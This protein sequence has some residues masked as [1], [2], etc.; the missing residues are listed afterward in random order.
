VDTRDGPPIPELKNCAIMMVGDPVQT[1]LVPSYQQ[2]VILPASEML[3][4]VGIGAS[5]RRNGEV[6]NLEKGVKLVVF[7]RIRHLDDD[8]IAALQARWRAAR[9]QNASILR[10]TSSD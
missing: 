10:G 4:G 9:G 5:Y 3:S 2:N 8:D 7:E 6:F 1:H